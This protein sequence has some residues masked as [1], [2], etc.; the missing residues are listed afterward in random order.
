[1]KADW[2]LLTSK[3][4]KKREGEANKKRKKKNR[5]HTILFTHPTLWECGPSQFCG[6]PPTVHKGFCKNKKKTREEWEDG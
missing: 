3:W 5:T 4:N 1:M 6:C 2:P